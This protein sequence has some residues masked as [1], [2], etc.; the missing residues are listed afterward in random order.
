MAPSPHS[1]AI[2]RAIERPSPRRGP[3]LLDFVTGRSPRAS[4]FNLS[5][6]FRNPHKIMSDLDRGIMKFKGADSPVA[7][8]L[9][10]TFILGGIVALIVWALQSAYSLS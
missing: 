2:D 5:Q 8:A 7:I 1:A 9:S 6:L 4:Y 3:Q 10:A